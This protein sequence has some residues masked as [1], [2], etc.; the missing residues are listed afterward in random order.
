MTR[1]ARAPTVLKKWAAVVMT[2]GV[3]GEMLW[4]I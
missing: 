2:S 3:S 1:V 4:K